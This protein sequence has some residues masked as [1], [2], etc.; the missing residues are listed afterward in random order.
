MLIKRWIALL[1]ISVCMVG[2]AL[3]MG[4]AWIYRE[5]DF[6]DR[7]SGMIRTLTLQFI[8]HPYRELIILFVGIPILIGVVVWF[9]YRSIKG[10]IRAIEHRPYD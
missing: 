10:L 9:F 2:L 5:Y 1:I 6:P 4:L 7:Y 8:A 3:A